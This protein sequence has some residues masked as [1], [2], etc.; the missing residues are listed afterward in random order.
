MGIT[1]SYH[2]T[3]EEA[4]NN[5]SPIIGLYTNIEEDGQIIHVRLENDETG[6]ASTTTLELIVNPIPEIIIPP[7]LE[8]CDA[9][10]DGVTT[11]D[12]TLL[13]ADILNG[14]DGQEEI[15]VTYH[16][17]PEEAEAGEN[18]IEDPETYQNLTSPYTQELAVRL[19]NQITG[20][21]STT[22]QG[23]I[24][25]VPGI[26]EVT[27]YEL[28]DYTDSGDLQEIFDITTKDDENY[29]RTEC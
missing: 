14:Q 28:C 8:V 24:V 22:V 27:D 25:N 9:N 20:C 26:I 12:L 19:E 29:Q 16:L 3:I 7:T 11:I 5:E 18:A 2:E 10:Y 23:I 1:V 4:E 15:N 13:D 6:C 17:T 21:Y